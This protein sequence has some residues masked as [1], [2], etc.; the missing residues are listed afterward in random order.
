MARTLQQRA[1]FQPTAE[2][3]HRLFT[4]IT[5]TVRDDKTLH[6]FSYLSGGMHAT[7]AIPIPIICMANNAGFLQD[8]ILDSH[9]EPETLLGCVKRPR[10]SYSVEQFAAVIGRG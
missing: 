2:A 8:Q 7:P 10:R 3:S 6:V 1:C 4:M 5:V 9:R